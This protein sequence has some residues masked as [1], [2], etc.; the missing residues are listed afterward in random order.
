MCFDS[1]MQTGAL[2]SCL[3]LWDLFNVLHVVRGRP[4]RVLNH[5]FRT[6][7][8]ISMSRDCVFTVPTGLT[9]FRYY[10]SIIDWS[11]ASFNS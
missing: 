10:V 4:D 9:G 7:N 8:N 11:R 2:D 6:P 5:Y 3:Q 1:G